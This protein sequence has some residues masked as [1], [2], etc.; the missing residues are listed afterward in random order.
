MTETES[1]FK[2]DAVLRISSKLDGNPAFPIF[3]S[4]GRVFPAFVKNTVYDFV[5]ENRY[6]FG[7]ETEQC[8]LDFGE[9]DDRFFD[10]DEPTPSSSTKE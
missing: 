1:Y 7:G 10:D 4:V 8:R 3:G 9:F 5:S 6:K 2:S